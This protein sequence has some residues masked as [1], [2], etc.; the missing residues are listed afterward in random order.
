[1]AGVPAAQRAHFQGGR[2]AWHPA[3]YF[4]AGAQPYHQPHSAAARAIAL[5]RIAAGTS[6]LSDF[7]YVGY[8]YP[9]YS[10]PTAIIQLIQDVYNSS[11]LRKSGQAAKAAGSRFSPARYF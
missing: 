7:Q 5:K 2:R 9:E 10:T 3:H 6:K 1:L 11:G 8:F 4:T